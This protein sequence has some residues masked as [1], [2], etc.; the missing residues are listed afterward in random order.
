MTGFRGRGSSPYSVMLTLG[1]LAG[2]G[3]LGMT[4]SQASAST[5]DDP[6]ASLATTSAVAESC[7]SEDVQVKWELASSR[8][9]GGYVVSGVRL[10]NLD[11][12][13][14]EMDVTVTLLGAPGSPDVSVQGVAS[15]PTTLLSLPGDDH[16]AVEDVL[17]SELVLGD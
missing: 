12:R 15:S 16:P 2:A 3:L 6:L 17:S 8:V 5:V 13:C 10:D 9:G 1:G 11:D 14:D 7:G 4:L